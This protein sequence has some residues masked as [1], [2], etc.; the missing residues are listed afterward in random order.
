MY[1]FNCVRVGH[2]DAICSFASTR[3]QTNPPMPSI[4]ME[5]KLVQMDVSLQFGLANE[6]QEGN[7]IFQRPDKAPISVVEEDN[8]KEFDPWLKPQSRLGRSPSI[9]GRGAISG[10]VYSE[11]RTPKPGLW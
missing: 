3:R 6:E 4:S 7:D 5:T 2:G 1:C 11:S 9:W 8:E 10:D